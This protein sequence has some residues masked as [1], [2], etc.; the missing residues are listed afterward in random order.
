MALVNKR[1]IDLPERTI[2]RSDDYV[3]VDSSDGGTAKYN[4]TELET[5]V[6]DVA[7]IIVNTSPTAT[8]LALTDGAEDKA[9]KKLTLNLLPH[10]AGSGVPSPSNVRAIS[11]YDAVDVVR[12][13]K[14]LLKVTAT[15]R[16]HNGITWTVNEDGSITA[17]GTA[18]ANSSIDIATFILPKGRYILNG[19]P[20]GGA[21]NKYD[22]TITS[23]GSDIGSG[24]AFDSDGATN[25]LLR[26]YVVNGKTVNNLTFYPMIRLESISDPT[27][28]PY[29]SDTYPITLPQTVYGGELD[30]T[31]GVLKVTHGMATLTGSE[32]N[33]STTAGIASGSVIARIPIDSASHIETV[34]VGLV[35]NYLPE[36]TPYSSWRYADP[37]VA[38]NSQ[39]NQLWMRLPNVASLADARTYLSEHN[40]TVVYPL[41]TPIEITLDPTTIK[42][43]LGTN[44]I[45]MSADGTIQAD[46]PADTKM[47]ID[48]LTAPDDDM[49]ANSNIENGK[50][51][52]VNNKLYIS[53]SAIAQGEQIVVGTNCTQ[54]DLATALNALNS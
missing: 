3:A 22:L 1:I 15:G 54:T 46:Y 26:A 29:Q 53:T 40:L 36:T 6:D 48:A 37:S 27:Y 43:L 28:E 44:T 39:G 33:M 9:V 24:F 14:N 47:Y 23:V 52:T 34:K 25:R 12:T 35:S 18:T 21:S 19:C 11:G 13:G 42:T 41:A 49:V 16:T 45:W 30:A 20:T 5:A 51:F 50:Y 4:I 38:T 7:P 31:K 17:N 8:V 32:S 2:L 10:Q